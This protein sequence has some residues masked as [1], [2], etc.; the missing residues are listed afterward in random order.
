[1]VVGHYILPVLAAKQILLNYWLKIIATFGHVQRYSILFRDNNNSIGQ[2]ERRPIHYACLNGHV[3]TVRLLVENN[4][5]IESADKVL[6]L[7]MWLDRY[8][9]YSLIQDLFRPIHVTCQNGHNNVVRLLIANKC[10]IE[11]PMTVLSLC[12]T[13]IINVLFRM[14]GGQ[15]VLLANGVIL[16]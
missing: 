2:N 11:A 13:E 4:C 1:M 8:L 3:D 15:S 12:L 16:K 5:D 14:I 10:D 9:L 6:Q 7:L